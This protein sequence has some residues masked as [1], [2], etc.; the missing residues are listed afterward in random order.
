MG[1]EEAFFSP[2]VRNAVAEAI[3]AKSQ[4][5]TMPLAPGSAR[6]IPRAWAHHWDLA[7]CPPPPAPA[8]PPH[9]APLL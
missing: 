8:V 3:S 5:E 4:K 9:H 2:A 6:V 1:E 7:F